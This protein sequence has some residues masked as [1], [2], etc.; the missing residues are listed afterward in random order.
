MSVVIADWR[1]IEEENP[2]LSVRSASLIGEGWTSRAYLVNEDLVFRFPKRADDWG[3]LHRE[4]AFLA[5]AANALPLAVPRYVNVVPDSPAAACG[6]AVYRYLEGQAID[7]N[8]LTPERRAAAA[9]AIATFLKALH[10]YQPSRDVGGLLPCENERD[11]AEEYLACAAREIAPELHASEARTLLKQFEWFLDTPENFSFRPVV[12]HADLSREHV[13]MANGAVAAV[14]DFGDVNWGDPDY[15]F[16]YLFV[17]F[18]LTFAEDVARRYGHANLAHL[19]PKLRYFALVDQIDT[20]INGESRALEGQKEM[21]WHR[22][23]YLLDTE[24]IR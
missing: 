5:S 23:R 17:D 9:D 8:V 20:I 18:G 6:Y 1:R 15:D 24:R 10:I 14:I 21:A 11:V 2:G 22:L 7:A 3:E 13:L 19:R 12:L 16:M 4:I